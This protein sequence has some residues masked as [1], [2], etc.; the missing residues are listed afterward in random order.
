MK[1]F[2]RFITSLTT[3]LAVFSIAT[4][5]YSYA[6]WN[7]TFYEEKNEEFIGKGIQHEQILRFT[8][9]GWYS[10]NV[11]RAD[12]DNRYVSLDLLSNETGIGSRERLSQLV[13]QNQDVIAAVNGDFF[14][15]KGAASLGPMVSDGELLSTP[16]YIPEKMATF[17]LDEDDNAFIDFWTTPKITITNMRNEQELQITTVNKESEYYDISVL[18]TP[19]YGPITPSLSQEIPGAVTMVISDDEVLEILPASVEGTLIPED[20]YVVFA[21]GTYSEFI[22]NNFESDD[23]IQYDIESSL[24]IDELITSI[25]G[26]ALLVENGIAKDVFTH[27]IKGNHPRTAIGITTDN[28]VILV[29]VDGRTTSFPGV[30]QQ[31]LAQIMVDLGAYSAVNMDGGGSTEMI[32]RP[33]GDENT[34]IIN[35]LSDW[36]ER[37]IA[38]GIGISSTAPETS[39]KGIS[40]STNDSNVFVNTKRTLTVKGYDRNYNP[41]DI[42]PSNVN[43][44]VSGTEGSVKDGIFTPTSSGKAVIT[45]EYKNK[46]ATIE[47]KVLETPTAITLS[48]N[49]I[50]ISEEQQQQLSINAV[51]NKGF[52]A[53]IDAESVDLDIPNHLGYVDKNGIFTA[54]NTSCMGIISATYGDLTAYTPVI[55]GAENMIIDDFENSNG[56]FSSYPSVVNGSYALTSFSKAGQFSGEITFDFSTTDATRAAY[57]VFNNNGIQLDKKP[58]KIGIWV[59]GNESGGHGLKVKLTDAQGTSKNVVLTSS[60]DFSGWN[61]VEAKIPSTLSEPIRIEQV[62]VVET[63]PLTQDTGRIYID[64]LTVSYPLSFQGDIPAPVTKY[65]DMNNTKSDFE[66]ESAFSFFAHGNISRIDTLGDELIISKFA[67]LANS[68]GLNVYSQT[69][70]ESL[71]NQLTQPVIIANNGYSFTEYNGS[72]F[73]ALDNNNGGLRA[74]NVNQW[75]WFLETLKQANVNN[76]FITLPKS[77]WFRDKLE[78]KLFKDTLNQLVENENM[79]VWVLYGSNNA[80][81]ISQEN[82]IHYVALKNYPTENKLD[83]FSDLDTMIFTVN[84]DKVT[85]E[86]LPLFPSN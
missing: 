63:D 13:N 72:G 54:A 31:E 18:F 37:R 9:V 84:E 53:A 44:S 79:D 76:L 47:I 41:M 48:P 26:G 33:L 36:S 42:D 34:Q 40:L 15:T 3:A 60:I 46:E 70:D 20:G 52:S 32:L 81:S 2:F 45:G 85:Y 1:R 68:H 8:D 29:T 22:Q 23:E 16:F 67:E 25:G 56:Q 21:T 75:P 73:F 28:E 49:K 71:R 38:N 51:D 14:N 59:Y 4:S 74:S 58:E 6:N 69:I 80:Y 86:I 66:T 57:L 30:S 12:I 65:V 55:V 35:H 77:L 64:D 39:I 11:L 17:N 61:Y 7:T 82:G 5:S 43:W 78:E 27:E 19:K 24:D 10:V 62:Y 50:N 83:I